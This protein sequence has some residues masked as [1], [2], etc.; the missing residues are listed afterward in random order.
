MNKV[1][2][3]E[4]NSMTAPDMIFTALKVYGLAAYICYGIPQGKLKYED[5]A[6][7]LSIEGYR[8]SSLWTQKDLP[9]VA[10]NLYRAAFA[11]CVITLDQAMEKAFGKASE[12]NLNP[13]NDL[14][15]ARAIAYSL[16]CSF[17]HG[18][19]EPNWK[20]LRNKYQKVWQIKEVEF[21]VDLAS[22]Y[23]KDLEMKHYGGWVGFMKL[24]LYCHKQVQNITGDYSKTLDFNLKTTD[25]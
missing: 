3:K 10:E 5:F 15:S 6:R 14:D 2:K 22:V 11:A 1:E 12:K 23:G 21:I 24:L 13:L 8:F 17:A 7:N 4:N 25:R 18:I 9:E 16:R 20:L 19:T